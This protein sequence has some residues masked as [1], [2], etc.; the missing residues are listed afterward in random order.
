MVVSENR[1]L[2]VSLRYNS[3][4]NKPS[5]S[6][7]AIIQE[8]L[9]AAQLLVDSGMWDE[10]DQLTQQVRTEITWHV[11][12][13]SPSMSETDYPRGE[14][15]IIQDIRDISPSR[16]DHPADQ[17]QFTQKVRLEHNSEHNS[18]H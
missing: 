3:E 12:D 7:S 10:S 18:D 11:K 8:V 15:K 5:K 1:F 4:A 14:R 13:R 16:L 2:N 9:A 6:V 17:R